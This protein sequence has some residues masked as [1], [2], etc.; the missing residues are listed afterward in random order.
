MSPLQ[1]WLTFAG[2]G[3]LVICMVVWMFRQVKKVDLA[4]DAY[5]RQQIEADTAWDEWIQEMAEKH[6]K[7]AVYDLPRGGEKDFEARS[8]KAESL[9]FMEEHDNRTEVDG[10][11]PWAA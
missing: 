4:Q 1:Y 10:S 9:G 8:R 11:D 5:E 6:K 7:G 2:W 3:V